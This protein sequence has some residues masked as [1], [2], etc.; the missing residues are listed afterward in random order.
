MRANG[1]ALA[2]PPLFSNMKLIF[3]SYSFVVFINFVGLIYI[4]L[5][6]GGNDYLDAPSDPDE[7]GRQRES[8]RYDPHHLHLSWYTTERE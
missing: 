1:K 5:T 3:L 4:Y 7:A 8:Q 6:L 2:F